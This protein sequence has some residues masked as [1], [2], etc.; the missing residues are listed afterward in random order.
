MKFAHTPVLLEETIRLLDIR[1]KGIYVDGTLGGGGHTRA[2]L[3]AGGPS[4]RVVGIDRDAEALAAATANLAKFEKQVT[5]IHDNYTNAAGIMESIGLEK[6]EGVLLDLGV[7]SYQLDNPERGFSYHNDA[8]LDMRMDASQF[9][10][11][12]IVVNE[13]SDKELYRVIKDYGEEAHA[14]KIA[15]HIVR[16]REKAPIETTMDLVEVIKKAVPARALHTKPHPAR[17]TFM[18]LRIEVNNELSALEAAV[19]EWIRFLKPGGRICVITF[20]SLEDRIIKHLFRR[21]AFPCDCPVDAPV[22]VCGKR[23]ELKLVGR[24]QTPSEEELEKN[25]RSKSARVRCAEKTNE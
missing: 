12:R 9:L 3:Q 23:P 8:P 6:V 7:S 17:R 2:I 15:Q 22:C 14:W 20:H 24:A 1:E 13:Y 16:R 18:A 4:V 19:T 21:M 25:P 10:N 11:A 5:F